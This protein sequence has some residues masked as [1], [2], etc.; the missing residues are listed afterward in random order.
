MHKEKAPRL[1]NIII[2]LHIW[3]YQKERFRCMTRCVQSNTCI[4]KKCLV[5][6]HLY[7]YN[8][9]AK[10]LVNKLF[11]Q[12]SGQQMEANSE[13]VALQLIV[14]SRLILC[15]KYIAQ[16]T[17]VRSHY[18]NKDRS[19]FALHAFIHFSSKS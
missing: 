8:M 15:Y 14:Y 16:H 13:F 17:C 5:H 2:S 18:S 6:I 3:L 1:M 10:T 4:N 12:C 9:F 11:I 19:E 7:L